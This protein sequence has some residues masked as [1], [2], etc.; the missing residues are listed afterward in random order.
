[1]R[2]IEDVLGDPQLAARKML[3]EIALGG[4]TVKVPG[5]PVKLSNVR[6]VA[7]VP[8]PRLG[9]HNDEVG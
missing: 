9:Q 5:N 7:Q 6:A 4:G 3:F 8:P 1:M 2:S